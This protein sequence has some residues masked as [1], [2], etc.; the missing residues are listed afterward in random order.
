MTIFVSLGPPK[1]SVPTLVGRSRD[2]IAALSERGLERKVVDVYSKEDAGTSSPIPAPRQP[3]EQG[4]ERP[5]Q[6]LA[7][8][9]AGRSPD[10]RRPDLRVGVVAAQGAGFAVARQDV[11][12]EQ[13]KGIVV[14]QNPA[15]G[16]AASRGSTVTLS[17][18]K[19]RRNPPSP[20]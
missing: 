9:P 18:S 16:A 10:G 4:L 14:R 8:P 5:H 19:G 11:D 15:G 6:R 13:P 2:A 12:S 17:V 20:T 1:V 7:G 3:G